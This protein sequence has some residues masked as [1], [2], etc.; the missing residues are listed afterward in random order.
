M[1]KQNNKYIAQA[2]K[3]RRR[4]RIIISSIVLAI[5]FI[6]FALKSQYFVVS[7]VA[8]LG[9]PVISGE[10]IKDKTEYLI[11]KKIFFID[12]SD[13]RKVVKQ[14]PYVDDIEIS[15][16]YPRQVNIKISEKQGIY[17]C[18]DNGIYIV[19]DKT[20]NILENTD[21]IDNRNLVRLYGLNLESTQP[22]E[23]AVSNVRIK[24]LLKI[25]NDIIK[26]N[27]TEFKLDSID[28]TDLCDIKVY[29][30]EIEGRFG[31]DEDIIEKANKFLHVITNEQIGIKK[32]YVD[33]GF[34]G[35]PVY[36]SE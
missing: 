6:V 35:A 20:L 13:I 11:G 22:G 34:D 10:D 1:K 26:T 33:V 14:N 9:N 18:E 32:G 28:L 15:R 24:N 16:K 30:G 21:N 17:Y 27:P 7:K 25:F 2:Q 5:G 23:F 29:I 4:K 3:K 31:Y 19:M 8:I 36:Y 12:K